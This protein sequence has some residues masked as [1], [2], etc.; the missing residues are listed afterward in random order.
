MVAETW[1]QVLPSFTSTLVSEWH[2]MPSCAI[3]HV[4]WYSWGMVPDQIKSFHIGNMVEL[5]SPTKVKGL[6]WHL[7]PSRQGPIKISRTCWSWSLSDEAA[8]ACV[9]AAELTGRV[10]LVLYKDPSSAAW[11]LSGLDKLLTFHQ[12]SCEGFLL[13]SSRITLPLLCQCWIPWLMK[14]QPW[15]LAAAESWWRTTKM[16]REEKHKGL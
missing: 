10:S 6:N 9:P 1:Q 13:M 5:L 2:V 12:V 16:P 4:R 3:N 11:Q 14:T 15:V 8:I 7:K